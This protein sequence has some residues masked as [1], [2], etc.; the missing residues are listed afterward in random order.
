MLYQENGDHVYDQK[1]EENTQNDDPIIARINNENQPQSMIP[2][3]VY[4][5][6][7]NNNSILQ[8]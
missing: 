4:N 5:I 2:Y 3:V 1:E 7:V 6:I 8:G